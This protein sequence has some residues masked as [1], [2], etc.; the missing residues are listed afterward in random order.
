MTAM[1]KKILIAV[2]MLGACTAQPTHAN[3]FAIECTGTAQMRD[4]I[5]DERSVRNYPL[6]AQTYVFDEGA[7]RVQK[8]LIPRQ[9]FEDVC[10]RGGYIDSVT[11]TPGLIIVHSEKRDGLCDFKVNRKTGEGEYFSR[12]DFSPDRYSEIQFKMT[13]SPTKIPVFDF[14][15]NKF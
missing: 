13:C 10:F 14:S 1:F 15:K 8:A 12:A 4:K 7:K 11:F 9:Q 6:P 2:A 3:P 5:G